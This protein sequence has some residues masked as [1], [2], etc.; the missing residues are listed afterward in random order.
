M[1]VVPV[2]QDEEK[3]L[4]AARILREDTKFAAGKIA[5]AQYLIFGITIFLLVGFYQLQIHYQDYYSEAADRNRIK[6][7]P[8][9]AP[10][11]KILDRDGRVI[12]D[13]HASYKLLLSRET[14]KA[15]HVRPIAE[16]LGLDVE[17][18]ENKLRR[19]DRTRAK[20]EPIPIK[21]ELSPADIA[22]VESH[23]DA[24]TFPEMELVRS[25]TRVYPRDGVAAH[26]IGY[27]GEI[28]DNELNGA[29]FGRNKPG[30]VVGKAGIERTYNDLLTGVDGQR[31][32][33]VDN[34]GN[35]R[36]V[37]GYKPAEA[38][39]SLQLT[40]DLDLQVVAE[41]AL[42]GRRGAVVALDPRNGELLA[43]VSRPSYDSNRMSARLNGKEWKS[44]LTD[45][46]KPL[47][48]RAIQSQL[49]PGSTFKP[50]AAL[51]ALETGSID[52]DFSA[53][54]PGGA[55]WYGRYF[56]CHL[57]RGHGQIRLNGALAL[58]CDVFFYASGNRTGIDNLARYATMA[59]LGAKT[60]IDLPYEAS[61][62][63][64]STRWKLRT[65]REKWYAGETISV[66]IGQGALTLTPLQLAH[67][68]GGLAAGAIWHKPHL[69][70]SLAPKEGARRGDVNLENLSKVIQGMYSVVNGGGTGARSRLP[71]IDLCGKT[72]TAQIASNDLVKSSGGGK[73]FADNAWFVG[74]APRDNP[75]IA[76]VALVDHG[77]HGD[78]AAPL[79]RD[80]VKAYFDKKARLL[81]HQKAL[82][83]QR[84]GPIS[85][86]VNP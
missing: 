77:E 10:R 67:A 82:A 3:K 37:I 24:E 53:T 66:S 47:F 5:G 33:V 74:F 34:R 31:Q 36:E 44:L 38:G 85:L 54:C 30:D 48:N 27:V 8:V 60:G 80:V 39:R 86:G 76:V 73:E 64:P 13:N 50:I 4:D 15:E 71:G 56:K 17:E 75:E 49:A 45:P 57:K 59:G 68:I 6:A 78:R 58:S 14:L 23:R 84:V 65:Q 63:V 21:E 46:D 22:F 35:E 52:D 26:V 19:F 81:R 55:M 20:Y 2:D 70:K 7:L 62:V 18:L 1:P 83:M 32:V 40:I 61:G 16:G 11:G 41:L 43:M 42:D 69:V 25:H 28:S 9:L 12:V 72:G 51:A 79:V 29:E